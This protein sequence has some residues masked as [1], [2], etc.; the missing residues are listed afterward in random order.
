[1]TSPK[2]EFYLKLKTPFSYPK[3]ETRFYL[4]KCRVHSEGRKEEK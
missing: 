3:S 1:M 2:R 4:T